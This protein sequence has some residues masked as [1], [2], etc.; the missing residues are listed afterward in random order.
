LADEGDAISAVD[1]EPIDD[2]ETIIPEEVE[3]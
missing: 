2:V 3:A 1:E